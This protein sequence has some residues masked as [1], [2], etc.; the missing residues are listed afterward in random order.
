MRQPWTAKPQARVLIVDRQQGVRAAVQ[1]RLAQ[2]Q[3]LIVGE[4]TCGCDALLQIPD[5]RPNVVLLGST[6]VQGDDEQ[7]LA[8]LRR[9]H[10]RLA[11]LVY[12]AYD[13]PFFMAQA[14]VGG[15][16]G[17]LLHNA[18]R[19]LLAASVDA[20]A[21]GASCWTMGQLER[22]AGPDGTAQPP[23]A[24]ARFPLSRTERQVL[25]QLGTGHSERELANGRGMADVY[26]I[27]RNLRRKL[28]SPRGRM[29]ISP[30]R[31]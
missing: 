13:S 2:D 21:G 19:E 23:E 4:A 1:Q 30:S 18:S 3:V 27:F 20:A 14:L 7:E 8:R 26:R 12:S 11:I 6:R 24:L 5:A 25:W 29:N 9:Q 17:Y 28:S 10:P 22:I 31:S 16:C 15:A